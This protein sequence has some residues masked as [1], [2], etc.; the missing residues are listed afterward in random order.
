[1]TW[2]FS[3]TSERGR[4]SEW[5]CMDSSVV[6]VAWRQGE[7]MGSV[8]WDPHEVWN[9]PAIRL[10]RA[11][12]LGT[13]PAGIAT[14]AMFPQAG[15]GWPD[16]RGHMLWGWAWFHEILAV[17]LWY[18]LGRLVENAAARWR[19]IALAYLVFRAIS[20]PASLSAVP[21]G[22]CGMVIVLAWMG[23]LLYLAGRGIALVA[24]VVHAK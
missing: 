23:L 3:V 12:L 2:Q 1:M 20:V 15:S 6:T 7:G 9:G 13:L 22:L 11:M 19:R 17:P 16:Q 14:A 24:R 4:R 18:V 10:V 21:A 5:R 8:G